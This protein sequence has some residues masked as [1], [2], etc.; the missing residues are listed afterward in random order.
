[1]SDPTVRFIFDPADSLL[2][3]RDEHRR[4]KTLAA[5]EE[6]IEALAP[7]TILE[8]EMFLRDGTPFGLSVPPYVSVT[9]IVHNETGKPITFTDNLPE[10]APSN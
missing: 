9:V 6:A 3:A 1:V 5:L 10:K 7:N 4:F 2:D 8:L